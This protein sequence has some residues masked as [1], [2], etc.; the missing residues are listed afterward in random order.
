[1]LLDDSRLHSLKSPWHAWLLPEA[2]ISL[3]FQLW[4][5]VCGGYFNE[6]LFTLSFARCGRKIKH[7]C[8]LCVIILLPSF[9]YLFLFLSLPLCQLFFL[10]DP[11]PESQCD[12]SDQ[13]PSRVQVH[14][15]PYSLPEA[16][17]IPGGYHLH[18][19]HSCHQGEW[20]LLCHLH[21]ALRS[22]HMH[23]VTIHPLIFLSCIHLIQ[24]WCTMNRSPVC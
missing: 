12:L 1:M 22:G 23:R 10:Q 16:G 19:E 21:P 6:G 17:Q 9:Y 8:S 4:L 3:E 18:G 2:L 7:Q 20:H 24:A 13:F 5:V 14:S 11:Q 15:R